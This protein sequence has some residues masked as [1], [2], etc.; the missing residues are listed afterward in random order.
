ME[1]TWIR[2][3]FAPLATL[4]GAHSLTDDA[5]FL[6]LPAGQQL[7]VT[8]DSINAGIHFLGDE[9]PSQLARKLLRVNL[10]DL[11]A[12]GAT[13]YCYFVNLSLPI[14]TNE[15]WIADFAKGL[16]EDQTRYNLS[17][18]GGDTT[19]S[20]GPLSLTLTALGLV[21]QGQ[22]ITRSG[23]REGDLLCVTGT[24]G[25]A[26][27]GLLILQ[28]KLRI[29]DKDSLVLRYR[30]PQPR[31]LFGTALRGIAH[32]AMD[33]SDGLLQDAGHLCRASNL[34]AD[35]RHSALPLSAAAQVCLTVNPNLSPLIYSGG[36]DYE[37]LL[38]IPESKF[39]EAQSL[40]NQHGMNL[41]NIGS[42][43]N[44]KGEIRLLNAQDIEIQTSQ[45]GWQHF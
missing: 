19:A 17:L 44:R 21:P 28:N 37:L 16:R 42:F 1:F 20:H 9:P 40:A 39:A 10:S 5:A 22:A 27:L 36:D 24:L 14:D 38:A 6:D 30:L 3:Y 41:H 31:I 43:T 18:A 15:D 13:P 26:A 29:I 33:I 4:P 34:G 23:A 35:I 11:A 2:T 45:K 12:K 8:T 7:V 25:D 32:A